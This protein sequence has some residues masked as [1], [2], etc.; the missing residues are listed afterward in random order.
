MQIIRSE[1]ILFSGVA[2]CGVKAE[3]CTFPFDY[4][5]LRK[6]SCI[7]FF[8]DDDVPGLEGGDEV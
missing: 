3:A 4:N 8:G 5:G 1:I 6:T 7:R 2:K